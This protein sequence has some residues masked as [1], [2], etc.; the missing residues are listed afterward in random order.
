MLTG[1]YEAALTTAGED[2]VELPP[3][4]GRSV[5]AAWDDD[6]R[7]TM[8]RAGRA[9]HEEALLDLLVADVT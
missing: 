5:S 9:V 3:L 4:E 8:E 6:L 2:L 7:P 1:D